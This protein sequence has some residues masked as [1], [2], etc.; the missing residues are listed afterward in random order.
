[1]LA[2]TGI[3]NLFDTNIE[4]TTSIVWNHRCL[5]HRSSRKL[6]VSTAL[7]RLLTSLTLSA[8]INTLA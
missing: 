7:S 4:Q 5:Q 2:F 1:M 6:R 3:I 8:S